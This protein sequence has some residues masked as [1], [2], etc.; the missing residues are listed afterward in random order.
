MA[1]GSWLSI[2]PV[3]SKQQRGHA[4]KDRKEER[5]VEQRAGGALASAA[6]RL[7]SHGPTHIW[8]G[9]YLGPCGRG[10]PAGLRWSL[11]GYFPSLGGQ[12]HGWR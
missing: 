10:H 2:L 3:H 11:C 4:R 12:P 6:G 1:R 9:S 5:K 7:G 8:D